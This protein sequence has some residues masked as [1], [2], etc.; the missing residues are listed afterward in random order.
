[1]HNNYFFLRQLTPALEQKLLHFVVATCFSQEKDE[2]VIGFTNGTEDF[3]IKAQ[4]SS[5][6]SAIS[7]PASFNRARVNSVDLFTQIIG[8]KVLAVVQQENERSFYLQLENNLALLFKLFGNRANII[9]FS[10]DEVVT[11]FQHKFTKDLELR[12]SQ[13]GR[14]L[15][16]TKEIF[17]ENPHRLASIYPTLGD[18]PLLYL[19]E[20]N[21]SSAAPEQQWQL[22]RETIALLE[23]PAFYISKI[24]GRTRL[25]LLPVGEIRQIFTEP[26]AAL[27]EF[28]RVYLS[29][30]HFEQNYAALLQNLTKKLN[31]SQKY[32]EEVEYKMLELEYDSTLS[33][34][35]DLIMANLTNIRP[36]ATEVE[37]FDFYN[38][39]QK[40]IKLPQKESP[41]KYAER[42]YKKNKNRQIELRYLSD[43]TEAK[44]AEIT[45]LQQLLQILTGIQTNRELKVFMKENDFMLAGPKEEI[46]SLF[47]TFETGG[48]K[49][50]VGK[51]AKNNDLLTQKHSYKEDLWLHAKDVAGS[52]VVIK[53]QAG[54]PFPEPVIEK[55][56]Q[57]AA[58]YSKRKND[59]LCPVLYTPK[60][61][62]RKPKGAEPGAVIVEREKVILVKPGN[63]FEQ[64]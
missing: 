34:T 48:F 4:L 45:K 3:Y 52:H 49:I 13:M 47:R 16:I 14:N 32:L 22:F 12:L 8:L 28:V 19:N 23:N 57:L 37:V 53:Y 36:Q 6:F 60:K 31:G 63:P 54:K 41:Q 40:K 39:T 51:S 33:Q 61:F 25:V 30:T 17:L 5:Q 44:K 50:L 64:Y 62:V 24:N 29:E 21:Y 27:Q 9:L 1:M 10:G 38:N 58:W 35:A 56:A 42:L 18:V 46:Q 2:L 7:F 15:V 20:Q 11:I 43:R 55:A 26:I 59:S